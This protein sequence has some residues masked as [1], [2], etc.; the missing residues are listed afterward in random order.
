LL[1]PI[2]IRIDLV[3]E[4]GALF[5]SVPRKISLA[6]SVQFQPADPTAARHWI[7]PDPGVNGAT[8]PLDVAWETDVH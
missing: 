5:T 6:V 8:L 1:L 3:H 4:D 7:L 2:T